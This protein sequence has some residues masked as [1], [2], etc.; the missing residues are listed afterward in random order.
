VIRGDRLPV[1][2]SSH[3]LALV[4]S[5]DPRAYAGPEAAPEVV[6]V[7]A[8]PEDMPAATGPEVQPP[9]PAP[10][11]EGPAAEAGEL[12]EPGGRREI[13]VTT[14]LLGR[15]TK[16]DQHRHAGGRKIVE[17][18]DVR[19][20]GANGI[21]EALAKTPGVRAV[22]GNSGLG[23]SATKLNLAVR[24]AQPR[25]S[26]QAT[27][28]L[29]EVPVAP[30]VYGATS[31]VMFPLS[32]FQIARVDT[33]R[34]GQSV[35]FGPWSSGGVF[36]MVSHPIPKNPTVKVYGQ[37]DH[38]GDASVGASYGGTHR[39]IGVYV[40]YAPRFGKTYRDHSE[41]QSH[42]GI[43]KLHVPIRSNVSLESSS[44]FFWEKTNLPG[45]LDR[46]SYMQDRFQSK[47][48][49]DFFDG[50]REATSLKLRWQ[51][52]ADHEFQLIAFYSHTLRRSVQAT[53]D[54]R[55]LGAAATYLLAQPRVFDVVGVEPR[56][57][58]RAHHR[59]GFHDIS[60]G[61]RGVFE[62]AR[63][64]AFRVEFP[65]RPGD[66]LQGEGDARVCPRGLVLPEGS[67]DA[68]RC[69]DGRIGGYSLYLEDKIYLLDT[70]L[71]LTAGVRVELTK[72]S[73]YNL[74]EGFAYPRPAYGGP[75]PGVSLWY[76]TDNVAFFLGYGRSLGAPSFISGLNAPINPEEAMGRALRFIK[77]ELADTVEA[78]VK[79]MELGGVYADVNGWYR[80]FNNLHDEGSDAVDV[81]PAAHA[82]GAEVSVE[83]EPGEV[84]EKV[85]GLSLETGYAHNGSRVLRDLYTGSRM[86]WYPPHEVWGK[87]SYE[88]PFGL[89]VGATVDY[90]SWQFTDYANR[91]DE[92]A[93]GEVGMMP[94]YTLMSAF[95]SF[96]RAL[97]SGWA[98]EL[99]FGV[100]NLL[101]EE[102]FTRSDD[103][104]GGR[105]AMRPRTFYFG[106][107]F[108]HEWIRGKAGEQARARR[109]RARPER[110]T[111]T[112][113]HRRFE[114]WFWKT[115]GAML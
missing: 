22:E 53:N 109:S 73:F 6:A 81:I 17:I 50:H 111:W 21:A 31:M 58:L 12:A 96:R 115:W 54:D 5:A 101:G 34:G 19:D 37:S 46:E 69:F 14:D 55:N 100:K 26:E 106:L 40:E 8:E 13:E 9:A 77:P 36:N 39:G 108:S 28:L 15:S 62:S 94:A 41:F 93:T 88:A 59:G 105:L 44:H 87:L 95:S 113:T 70:R 74:L 98:L 60:V 80:Y 20:Q 33:L 72:Q 7:Q 76:G 71:V 92:R 90:T 107:G 3:A 2:L 84:W 29:D 83:W 91:V 78:G 63:I 89:R 23:T 24:G 102:W 47:R 27:I 25:L 30:A 64:R 35:R 18:K 32:L 99:T 51:P 110:R 61:T 48:P 75:L 85:E 11:P 49:Y 86:P 10:A 4:L 42:G 112:A 43:F 79:L 52:K 68:Q 97:P 16:L 45:G 67:P 82:Y 103:I 65:G 1:L 38:F 104:N 66:P 114:R 57:A 56:Y